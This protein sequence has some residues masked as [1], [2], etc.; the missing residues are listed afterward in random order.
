MNVSSLNALISIL[1]FGS[2]VLLAFLLIT[3]PRQVN[4]RANATFGVF[5]LLWASFWI[6]EVL[7]MTSFEPLS[8]WW[9]IVLR[10]AQFMTAILF[11]YAVIYFTRPFHTLGWRDL[12]HLI[13]P[14]LYT[15]GLIIEQLSAPGILPN[16]FF[17]VLILGMALYYTASSYLLLQEHE[18]RIELFTAATEN[19]DLRWIKQ[20][21]I[22]LLLISIFIGVYNAIVQ[23]QQLNIVA[24]L[25]MMG[26]I[27]FVA[28]NAIR[29][30]R[31]FL[32]STEEIQQITEEEEQTPSK[33]P[34][35]IPEGELPALKTKLRE[36]MNTERPYLEQTLN[37]KQLSAMM[38]LSP[39]QLSF[40]LNEGFEE[41]FFQFVNTY[42]VALAK[43]LL[44]SEKHS[45]LSIVGIG[46][47][48]GFNSKTA[49][50][51]VFK[52][53]TGSTPTQFKRAHAARN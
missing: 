4:S 3:N 31:I 8:G 26:A 40:L 37:L 49:F 10:A 11:Y 15:A 21:I 24:N 33:K 13:L 47:E 5:M 27:Y 16:H 7:N 20:I 29:Q 52:K 36:L 46:F 25:T 19:I 43:E 1:I 48:A 50:N 45:H 23:S 12:L 38:Q 51:T 14:L 6:D 32:I 42:R 2:L 39:H 35:L 44:I 34:S 18:K 30:E 22:A 53:I 9:L 28:Y 41:N 17:T